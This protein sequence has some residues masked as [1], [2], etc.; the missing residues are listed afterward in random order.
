MK[1]KKSLGQN[2]LVDRAALES[3]AAHA[4]LS[5]DNTVLEIGPGLGYLTDKLLA[6]K[7]HV[8]ALEFDHDLIPKLETKYA[9]RK[10][11]PTL[12]F[13]D[14]RT[15][16]F[17][18]LPKEYSICANIPYYLTANLLRRLTDGSNKPSRAVLLVQK[19]VAEKLADSRRRSMLNVLVNFWY[20]VS[21]EE[22]VPAS[23]FEPPPKVDSQIMVLNRKKQPLLAAEKWE[24]YV[25]LI[26]I[27]YSN[28]RKMLRANIASGF[29]IQKEAAD[30][31]LLQAGIPPQSRA[32]AVTLD[33]WAR[34]TLP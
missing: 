21:A 5:S 24:D 11:Q 2:W 31:I 9:G 10:L 16:D 23:S 33:S 13:G 34:L 14:I 6:T 4:R 3:I 27:G 18:Q 12:V 29:H 1:N 7:A 20:E 26:K 15:Y 19:E 17:S 32:E 8:I 25:R 22:V 28:P 30:T